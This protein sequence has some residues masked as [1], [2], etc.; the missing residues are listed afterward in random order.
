MTATHRRAE[1]ATWRRD[2]RIPGLLY[3]ILA[4]GL[5]TVMMLGGTMAPDYLIG[6]SAISDLGVIPE[7]ASLFNG[8]LVVVGVLQ[9][10]ASSLYFSVH[11]RL[12]LVVSLVAAFGA[13][14]VGLVPL[15]RG[16]LHGLFALLAFLAFN[17]QAI[18]TAPV[19]RSPLRAIC[20]LA[21]V[22]GLAFLVVMVVGDA[23]DAA[24]LGPIGHGG[25]ERMIVYPPLL[26][27][28]ALGD[29]LMATDT[30]EAHR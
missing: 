25:V 22:S 19:V 9:A 7:T 18:V 16:G 28:L 27:L 24:A 30:T 1:G 5:L 26:W 15:D 3:V 6:E 29:Y 11:R 10:V 13:T 2:L 17:L 14:G 20:W 12:I 21:G 8:S 23:F 4:G